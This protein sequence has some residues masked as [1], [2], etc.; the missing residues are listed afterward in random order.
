MYDQR[1]RP[2]CQC[3][4]EIDVHFYVQPLAVVK[5]NSKS[6]RYHSKKSIFILFFLIHNFLTQLQCS[7]FFVKSVQGSL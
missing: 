4:P 1:R 5:I 6:D 2:A 3:P 7:Y